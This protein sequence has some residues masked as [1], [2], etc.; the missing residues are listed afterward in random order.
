MKQRFTSFL[1]VFLLLITGALSA[2]TRPSFLQ[3]KDT[4]MVDIRAFGANGGD[5]VDD[6]DEIQAAIDSIGDTTGGVVFIPP[7]RFKTNTV[8]TVP[9]RVSI[10]GCGAS[11][12]IEATGC[13]GLHVTSPT[14]T[15]PSARIFRDFELHG[16]G[17][18][19]SNTA[20]IKL[21]DTGASKKLY[22]VTVENVVIRQFNTGITMDN[23]W[24]SRISDCYISMGEIGIFLG[25]QNIKV[26]I[27]N[28]T[29]N[30]TAEIP[31]IDTGLYGIR[32]NPA[33]AHRSE[34]IQISQNMIYGCLT[35][36]SIY[37]A[38]F[39]DISQN[40]LDAIANI[41][42]DVTLVNDLLTIRNNWIAVTG[43]ASVGISLRPLAQP[44]TLLGEVTGNI[45]QKV[46]TILGTTDTGIQISHNANNYRLSANHIKNF[47][48]IGISIV[49][50]NAVVSN[51]LVASCT[52]GLRANI[53][54]NILVTGN[55]FDNAIVALYYVN[56]G[57]VNDNIILNSPAG[58]G[59]L[60]TNLASN[61]VNIERNHGDYPTTITGYTVIEAGDLSKKVTF[62]DL[63]FNY[64]HYSVLPGATQ[65]HI[66][67]HLK[68]ITSS[69]GDT[70][71]YTTVLSSASLTIT[72]D[73]STSRET[74]EWEVISSPRYPWEL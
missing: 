58:K 12:V 1:I 60:V 33:S 4:P 25:E 53:A 44:T 40:D 34:D 46:G 55:T 31:R 21:G 18:T 37:S 29:I 71:S 27:I 52:I 42:I 43:S 49:G 9:Y 15:F 54:N 51:N 61:S 38:L 72:R 39:V 6:T 30:A 48:G 68:N 10:V 14:Y 5:A 57:R 45:I 50:A 69:D 41:G 11:S 13:S 59:I 74:F 20:G 56:N 19:G 67:P 64:L 70:A 3:L 2:Q 22:N 17:S 7:G 35:A 24:N 36:I 47:G 8:L 65:T 73:D 32:V 26:D 23:C 66:L 16:V 63:G 28:N 62:A